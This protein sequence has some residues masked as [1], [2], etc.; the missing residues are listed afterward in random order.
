MAK[1]TLCP[2]GSGREAAQCCEAKLL[3]TQQ[4]ETAEQLMRSR[5]TAF[6][7]GDFEYLKRTHHA[8]TLPVYE[9]ATE[10]ADQPLWTGL[11]I[12]STELGGPNDTVGWVDFIARFNALGTD[13][14]MREKSRFVKENGVWLYVDGKN[15]AVKHNKTAPPGRNE[16]CPCGS[17]KK[18]KKCC[19]L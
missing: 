8:S 9:K 3:G 12:L 5:Y 2:C 17:G 4:A 13:Q 16:P 6:C 15:L 10:A 14:A 19:G 1:N 7:K 18:Y 11:E